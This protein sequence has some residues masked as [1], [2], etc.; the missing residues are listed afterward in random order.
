MDNNTKLDLA[1][2][3]GDEDA[4]RELLEAG[5]TV[6]WRSDIGLTALHQAARRGHTN[7]ARL[8]VRKGWSLEVRTYTGDT[9]LFYAA[10]TGNLETVKY[11][12][13]R[14][15][16]IDTQA[17]NKATP[18]HMAAYK[19]HTDMVKFLL[20]A[21]AD[22]EIKD[23]FGNTAKNSAC[24]DKTRAVFKTN[25]VEMLQKQFQDAATSLQTVQRDFS[26]VLADRQTLVS[27]LNVN[28]QVKVNVDMMID[29]I[30]GELKRMDDLLT[31]MHKQQQEATEKMQKVQ[32]QMQKLE[33]TPN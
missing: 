8:L 17:D 15:A 12:V 3:N 28:M 5:A 24:N 4:V 21:G 14:G 10:L 20:E 11:L 33:A 25:A 16:Y 1:A 19:G 32:M 13:N 22:Q 27:Q 7:V 29:Y 30:R 26:K 23:R 6:D 31:N 18:L 2:E 9:P